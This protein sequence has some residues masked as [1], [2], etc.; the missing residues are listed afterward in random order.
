MESIDPNFQG[1]RESCRERDKA[2]ERSKNRGRR[3]RFFLGFG[4]VLI[5]FNLGAVGAFALQSL[6]VVISGYA[7]CSLGFIL[8]ATGV[9]PRVR[10][11]HYSGSVAFGIV[12]SG[13]PERELDQT[14][15]ES[16]LRDA[17]VWAEQATQEADPDI[18]IRCLSCGQ[19]NDDAARF[20]QG[21]G[22]QLQN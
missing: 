6:Y 10:Q 18:K 17:E 12:E 7:L 2:R 22:S 20:C 5:G 1:M 14:I 13:P 9:V 8:I 11:W 15:R 21:C 19:L 4:S 3:R 16:Q